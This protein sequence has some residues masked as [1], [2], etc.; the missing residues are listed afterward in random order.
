MRRIG[1]HFDVVRATRRDG[2]MLL[3]G[4]TMKV[5]SHGTDDDKESA[6]VVTIAS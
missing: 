1:H 5:L 3:L 6:R 2:A 4:Q